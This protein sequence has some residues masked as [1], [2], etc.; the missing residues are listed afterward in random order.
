MRNIYKL[1]FQL[2]FAWA[3]ATTA[4]ADDLMPYF[5]LQTGD[6]WT[7]MFGE[8]DLTE[9]R[10]TRRISYSVS[11]TG[12]IDQVAGVSAYRI[13]N[14]LELDSSDPEASYDWL[15]WTDRGLMNF[16][17]LNDGE[18]TLNDPPIMIL[19]RFISPGEEVVAEWRIDLPGAYIIVTDHFTH[20]GY[21]QL[22]T[23]LGTFDTVLLHNEALREGFLDDGTPLSTTV[24]SYDHWFAEDV[25]WLLVIT[26]SEVERRYEERVAA[27][28]D[29]RQIGSEGAASDV[30]RVYIA[31]YGRAADPAGS[32]YWTGRLAFEDHSL[33][34]IIDQFATSEEAHQRYG[35][36]DNAELIDT[37]Y[38]QM[39]GRLPDPDGRQFYIDSLTSGERTLQTIM[40]DVL[41]GA[42]NEDASIIANKL[43]V[44]RYF[45]AEVRAH[46]RAYRSDDIDQA[47][48]VLDM[49]DSDPASVQTAKASA[50]ALIDEMPLLY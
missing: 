39:F 37:L 18:E 6:S 2:C 49:V 24:I 42:Q 43:E 7:T 28:I 3:I 17:E 48:D 30:Q 41:Y 19:P 21:P 50:D 44:A 45:T 36:M 26:D 20:E 9:N 15:R 8:S 40:L 23:T 12:P 32:D 1:L 10:P 34:A 27:T 25:G 4:T 29:N 33:D 16:G 38:R 22:T 35:G 31:Y 11:Q 46:T 14:P 13:G 5:P 47:R